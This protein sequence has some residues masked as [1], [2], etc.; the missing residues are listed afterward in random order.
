M[1]FN[2]KADADNDAKKIGRHIQVELPQTK[3]TMKFISS[4]ALKEK[5]MKKSRLLK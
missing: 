2:L 3:T 5:V 4:D 1:S